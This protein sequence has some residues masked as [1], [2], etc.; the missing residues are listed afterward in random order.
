MISFVESGAIVEEYLR[1]T[2]GI[3]ID[4]VEMPNRRSLGDFDGDE[5]RISNRAT[6]EQR[7]F[8]LLHLFGHMVQWHLRPRSIEVSK[9][10]KPPV[11]GEL[12]ERLLAY[13]RDAGRY[14]MGLVLDIGLHGIARWLARNAGCDVEYLRH[15]Y[16]T[17]KRRRFTEF[18]NFRSP[19][20]KALAVPL[21]RPTA[22]GSRRGGPVI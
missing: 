3:R 7:L 10:R 19:V 21:F 22:R 8:L 5:I 18:L 16:V 12:L 14:A 9:L 13:E 20:I 6:A 1:R 15:Y 11:T 4:T 2:Y 17:G